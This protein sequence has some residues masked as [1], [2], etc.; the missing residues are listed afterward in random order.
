MPGIEADEDSGLRPGQRGA[1]MM[2]GLGRSHDG[3]YVTAVRWD[4]AGRIP[5]MEMTAGPLS[6]ATVVPAAGVATAA[7]G[8]PL[9]VRVLVEPSPCPLFWLR[10][11]AGLVSA[12]WST[13]VT[14]IS[15]GSL[16]TG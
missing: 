13:P 8:A 2:G 7:R 15:G 6:G 14:S 3:A 10:T 5:G 12:P 11:L 4:A 1:T 16:R 9:G